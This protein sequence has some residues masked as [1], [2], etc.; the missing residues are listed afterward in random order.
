VRQSGQAYEKAA[1]ILIKHDEGKPYAHVKRD[2]K[3]AKTAYLTAAQEG[4]N[5]SP[6]KMGEVNINLL[7]A[8]NCLDT[9]AK[10]Y[11]AE[12]NDGF[13]RAG[14]QRDV[15]EFY[16]QRLNDNRMAMERYALAA[17]MFEVVPADA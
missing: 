13:A 6:E 3:E 5:G 12:G 4:E 17:S 15:A 7:D 14:A 2:L 10:Y 16:L 11:D 8:V 1:E 9:T